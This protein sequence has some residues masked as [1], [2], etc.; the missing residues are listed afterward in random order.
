[1]RCMQE[2]K[3]ILSVLELGRSITARGLEL[4]RSMGKIFYQTP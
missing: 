1:M 4:E 3:Q 2:A